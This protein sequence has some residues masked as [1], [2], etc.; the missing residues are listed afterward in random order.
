MKKSLALLTVAILMVINASAQTPTFNKGDKVL[1]ITVGV[2]HLYGYGWGIPPIIGSFEV[3]IVDGILEKASIGV[4]GYAGVSSA[5]WLGDTYFNVHFG[6]KGAFHYPFVDKL[7]TYAGI[8]TG[9]SVSDLS[10]YGLDWGA[11][12]GIRYY[13]SDSFALNAEAGYGVTWLRGGIS[14][15]F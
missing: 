8:L 3:G 7:D 6:V 12:A 4:G 14:L 13:L 5:S 2:P 10:Y 1:D 15:K 11:F 9:Y